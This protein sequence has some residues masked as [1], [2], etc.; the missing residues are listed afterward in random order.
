[1]AHPASPSHALITI[2]KQYSSTKMCHAANTQLG[3][4]R[5]GGEG[6]GRKKKKCM[7]RGSVKTL[8]WGIQQQLWPTL[9]Y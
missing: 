6:G 2:Q 4:T 5:G 7:Q 3:A 9:R 1:M 8:T